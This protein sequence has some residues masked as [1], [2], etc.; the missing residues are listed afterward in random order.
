MVISGSKRFTV[1]NQLSI[2]NC[3]V[4]GIPQDRCLCR[5]KNKSR[6]GIILFLNEKSILIL[7]QGTNEQIL[8]YQDRDYYILSPNRSRDQRTAPYQY[9][10]VRRG[11]PW[12]GPTTLEI[13]LTQAGSASLIL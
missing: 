9:N 13:V 12:P 10:D 7:D 8:S 2:T 1:H 4:H 11:F 3:Q 5:E 6:I